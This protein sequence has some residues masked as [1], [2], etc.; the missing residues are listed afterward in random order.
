MLNLL[1]D[2]LSENR[3]IFVVNHSEMSDD[4]FNHKIRV[5]LNTKRITDHKKKE[6]VTVKASKYEQ[7]F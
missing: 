3:T 5:H 6:E 4:F 1:K 7:I 2:T